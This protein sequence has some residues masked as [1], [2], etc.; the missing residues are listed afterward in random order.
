MSKDTEKVFRELQ[1]YLDQF[2]K[3][4]QSETKEKIDEFMK[5]YN[6]DLHTSDPMEKDQWYYLDLAMEAEDVK[7]ARKNAQRALTIDPYCTDAE[8]LLIDLMDITHEEVKKRFEKLI[9]KTEAHLEE[10]GYFE[11]ANIGE[12]YLIY[13]TRPYMRA[14]SAY[15]DVLM[16][17]GKY[18][19]AISVGVKMI[20]LNQNDN[21][22]VRYDLMALHA[23]FEDVPSA[24]GLLAAYEEE[25]TS[26]LLPLILLYYRVDNYSKARKYLKLLANKNPDF[27][28]IMLEQMTEEE[29]DE[30]LTPY[31]FALNTV[32]ELLQVM[33]REMFLIDASAGAMLWIQSEL[34]KL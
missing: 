9:K 21:L 31:G 12:F 28:K 7:V 33:E 1:K 17:L 18:K 19:A 6:D 15:M 13:E 22:G 24:E 26:M 23:F 29:V 27:K 16:G 34:E 30:K 10:E 4:S 25:S 5:Q 8:L 11:E 20:K 32:G 2:G 3:L 14:L